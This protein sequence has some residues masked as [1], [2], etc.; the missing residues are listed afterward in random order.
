MFFLFYDGW[1][2]QNCC[3]IK[4]GN[5]TMS[6]NSTYF[7]LLHGSLIKLLILS[8]S[9]IWKK[10]VN[11]VSAHHECDCTCY[12]HAIVHT[13]E[14]N[15]KKKSCSKKY[16]NFTYRQTYLYHQ[17]YPL[18]WI[19]LQDTGNQSY[20][21]ILSLHRAW[22]FKRKSQWKEIRHISKCPISRLNYL[23]NGKKFG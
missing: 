17:N 2:G 10:E 6:C 16:R 18:H 11:I 12:V 23:R 7:L 13:L 5:K 15:K 19:L 4:L 22:D 1:N 21:K 14:N 3:Q 9:S 20:S 8:M